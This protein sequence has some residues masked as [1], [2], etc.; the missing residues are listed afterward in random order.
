MIHR[1]ED[2]NVAVKNGEIKVRVYTPGDKGPFPIIVYYHGGGFVFGSIETHDNVCRLL[3]RLSRSIVVSVDYRLA[4]ENKFPVAVED[5]YEALKWVANNAGKIEGD[6]SRICVAGDSAG[7]NLAAVMSII[8]RD[9]KEGLIKFQALIYPATDMLDRS[10]SLFE[11]S[12]GYFLTLEA[13]NWFGRQYLKGI[14]DALNP[15]ASPMRAELRGLPESLI[16][17]A[18][19]DPIR[20]QGETY[21][22]ILKINGNKVTSIRY[23][24]MIHGFI[25]LYNLVQSG[26]EAIANI[27]GSV[28]ARFSTT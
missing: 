16:I 17:T 24:G 14:E 13:I 27:A 28:L 2:F 1:V 10:P 5:S 20:D 6:S 12:E 9:K 25:S 4:P 8:D 3:S 11:F 19:Y 26:R 15:H 22:H 21:A 23:N 18:E 7:G